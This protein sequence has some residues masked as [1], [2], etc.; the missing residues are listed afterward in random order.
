MHFAFAVLLGQQAD[1]RSK[2]KKGKP[3]MVRRFHPLRDEQSAISIAKRAMKKWKAQDAFHFP[4]A[5]AAATFKNLPQ[6]LRSDVCCTWTLSA[7]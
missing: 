5:P 3:K 6:E 7:T 2:C 4:T 1:S